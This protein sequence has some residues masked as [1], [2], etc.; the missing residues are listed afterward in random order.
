MSTLTF[1][2]IRPDSHS[3]ERGGKRL[4]GIT[5]TPQWAEKRSAGR[6][7]VWPDGKAPLPSCKTLD[8]AKEAANELYQ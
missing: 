5:Q 6:W 2:E 3:I 4:G 7:T 1:R 8:E